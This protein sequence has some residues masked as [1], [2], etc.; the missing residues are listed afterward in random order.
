MGRKSPVKRLTF[1]PDALRAIDAYAKER[2]IG[3]STAVSELI[4][5]VILGEDRCPINP[6][7]LKE[8]VEKV[9]KDFQ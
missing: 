4:L 5:Y 1:K 7:V 2:G 6:K 9:R 8:I 3:R